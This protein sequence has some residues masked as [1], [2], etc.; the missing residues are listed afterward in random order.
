MKRPALALLI[1]TLA[2]MAC[3][4]LEPTAALSG[5]V[6][7]ETPHP[8]P[9][10]LLF[11]TKQTPT[12]EPITCQVIAAEALNVRNSPSLDGDVIAW[13]LPGDVARVLSTR[14]AWYEI[15]SD[16]GAGWI[17]SHYCEVTR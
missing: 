4:L 3:T 6:S 11:P 5:T 12:P 8:S 15:Q 9:A 7:T 13:L 17:H 1:L 10:P 2:A 16:R 14:G